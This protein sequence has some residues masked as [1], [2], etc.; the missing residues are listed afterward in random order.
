MIEY[1]SSE[2]VH[3]TDCVVL[4]KAEAQA[5]QSILQEE[6]FTYNNALSLM[7]R[8]MSVP[9]S[10]D[11][12]KKFAKLYSNTIKRLEP[13]QYKL[14]YNRSRPEQPNKKD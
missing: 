5:L 13:L 10:P 12:F 7:R 6:L 2:K 1:T 8:V 9:S 11:E 4:T 3:D 14:K